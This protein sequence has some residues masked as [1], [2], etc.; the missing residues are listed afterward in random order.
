MLRKVRWF[1][2]LCVAIVCPSSIALSQSNEAQQLVGRWEGKV[3][4]PEV[5]I[6]MWFSPSGKTIVTFQIGFDAQTRMAFSMN[7]SIDT[8][9]KPMHL[10]FR[11][12]RPR[13]ERD[14]QPLSTIFEFP[15]PG[16]LRVHFKNLEPGKP[17][18][19][20]F[21]E[22]VELAKFSDSAIV[23]PDAA[24]LKQVEQSTD[25]EGRLVMQNLALSSLYHSVETQQFPT[26]ARLGLS[27]GTTQ[28]YRY[29]LQAASDRLTL[30]ARPNKDN[31]RSY[32]AVV[33]KFPTEG[34]DFGATKVCQSV[35][36]SRIA[37]PMPKVPDSPNGILAR[38]SIRCG[39]GSE[40][41]DF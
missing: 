32:I 24:K 16:R 3:I 23:F 26:L 15:N 9:P 4:R 22:P 35:R 28:N 1:G 37:P 25:G 18:P 33:L 27:N 8:K 12:E 40:A 14:K 34:Q 38:E 21:S 5:P 19:T 36:P 20:Q 30:I 10:D 11:L 6:G 17:R 29:Q 41:I 13:S 31:L 39:I 7:Y 2:A